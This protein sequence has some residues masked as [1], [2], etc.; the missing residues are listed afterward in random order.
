MVAKV[1]PEAVAPKRVKMSYAEYLEFSATDRIVEWVDG[2]MIVYMPPKPR[3]QQIVFFLSQV[4][5]LF[6]EFFELGQILIAPLEVKLW[7]N[8][9]SREPDISF[10]SRENQGGLTADRLEGAP[11]L[12][13]E[14][15]SPT[16]VTEDR[17]RKFTQYEQAGVREYWIIDPRPR[18]EQGDFYRLGTDERY[19]SVTLGEEGRYQAQVIP[20]FWLHVDW[21]WQDP[22]PNP[23]LIFAEIMLSLDT[24]TPDVKSAYQVLYETL[25]RD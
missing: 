5:S 24:L 8:G 21:L 25:K 4:L 9:P 2:E 23:Q 3:H 13:I 19:Q 14:V 18:Q 1:V 15:I 7:P 12:I 20:N 16:S 10:I 6:V 17:V 11:D 22:L